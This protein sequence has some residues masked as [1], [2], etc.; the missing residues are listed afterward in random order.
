VKVAVDV[1]GAVGTR[2]G[3]I[4][5]DVLAWPDNAI[6]A[7][8]TSTRV[9][10]GDRLFE[11][12]WKECG[13]SFRSFRLAIQVLTADT[14]TFGLAVG[15]HVE[16][17]VGADDGAELVM[18]VTLPL[19]DAAPRRIVVPLV[20]SLH[21]P[22]SSETGCTLVVLP[23]PVLDRLGVKCCAPPCPCAG[24]PRHRT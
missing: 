22:T 2:T 15:A 4:R 20:V 10:V 7:R 21:W 24:A 17:G 11:P 18:E 1:T 6:V 12:S 8:D 19:V 14:P 13:S 5:T 9:A 3:E 23:V 16:M